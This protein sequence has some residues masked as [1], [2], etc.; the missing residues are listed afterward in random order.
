MFSK[1]CRFAGPEA[2]GGVYAV[3]LELFWIRSAYPPDATASSLCSNVAQDD[4]EVEE[5]EV[6]VDGQ[7][8]PA[9]RGGRW[10]TV[11]DDS[12]KAAA[13][14]SPASQARLGL[15]PSEVLQLCV[16]R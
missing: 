9:E 14:A 15:P 2:V 13:A 16:R 11:H 3:V 10:R 8:R 5:V 12:A 1:D 7:W 4:P 6:N